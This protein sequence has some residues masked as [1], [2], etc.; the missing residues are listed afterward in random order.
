MR[1][2]KN[3]P[4]AFTPV[5]NGTPLTFD[6]MAQAYLEDHVLQRYRT[7]ATSVYGPRTAAARRRHSRNRNGDHRAVVRGY[8]SGSLSSV[9]YADVQWGAKRRVRFRSSCQAQ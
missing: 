1:G 9:G 2:R 8:T 7:M 6:T 4:L 3:P 5:P